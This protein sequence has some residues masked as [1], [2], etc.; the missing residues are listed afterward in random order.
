MFLCVFRRRFRSFRKS[1]S[2][3]SGPFFSRFRRLIIALFLVFPGFFAC[4]DYE[5]R[6]V[7][8]AG[9]EGYLDI[10]YNVPVRRGGRRSLIKFLPV[11][12]ERIEKKYG[13][14]LSNYSVE[15]SEEKRK[16]RIQRKALVKFRLKFRR[17]EELKKILLGN[18]TVRRRDSR[19]TLERRFPV[20]KPLDKKAGRMEKIVRERILKSL[21]NHYLNFYIVGPPGTLIQSSQGVFSDERNLGLVFP[22]IATM[23]K[24]DK[25]SWLVEIKPKPSPGPTPKPVRNPDPVF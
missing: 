23:D 4:F 16:T 15:Y 9:F 17:P 5:E 24:K 10:Q 2:E 6:L 25:Y 18:V 11:S 3:V 22:L 12:R 1:C 13:R 7:F 14:R 19:L 20:A 8:Q 21:E